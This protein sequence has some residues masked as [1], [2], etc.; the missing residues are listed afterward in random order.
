MFPDS[1]IYYIFLGEDAPRPPCFMRSMHLHD[2]RLKLEHPQAFKLVYGIALAD[3]YLME[4]VYRAQSCGCAYDRQTTT[5]Q[6][7]IVAYDGSLAIELCSLILTQKP[8]GTHS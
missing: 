6:E 8:T 4:R 1:Q 2:V 3:R 5:A 7:A